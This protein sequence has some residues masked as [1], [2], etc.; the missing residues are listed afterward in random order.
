MHMKAVTRSVYWEAPEHRH[1]EKTMDWYWVVG[2][3]AISAS[4]AS[5]IFENILFGIVILL[6]AVVVTLYNHREPRIISF[7]ISSR[8]V[9]IDRDLYY[10]SSLES[11][12]I[13]DTNPYGPQL[14]IKSRG[15]LTQLLIM[16]L[17]EEHLDSIEDILESKLPE[18]HLE[19]P[20]THQILEYFGF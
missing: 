14:L 20:L 7:E 16:Q 2:I 9:R 12:Y 17:P 13:D 4:I 19:E 11:F 10:Y 18:E 3:I 15:L 6:G 8:G 1:V 5:I